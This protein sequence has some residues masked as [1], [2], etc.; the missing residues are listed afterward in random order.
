MLAVRTEYRLVLVN[1]ATNT[2]AGL[3]DR[4]MG[5][6]PA[7]WSPAAFTGEKNCAG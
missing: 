4:M 3:D 5:N 6:T 7:V 1:L 2:M